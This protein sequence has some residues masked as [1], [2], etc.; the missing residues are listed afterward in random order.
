MEKICRIDNDNAIE[1][2]DVFMD[3]LNWKKGDMLNI[4]IDKNNVITLNKI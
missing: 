2:P 1:I 4:E 3:E